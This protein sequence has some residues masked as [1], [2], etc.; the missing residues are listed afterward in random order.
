MT[1]EVHAEI[2]KFLSAQRTMSLATADADGVPMA[3]GMHYYP[4]G[5]R[6]YVSSLPYTK[7]LANI[8]VNPIVGYTV[9]RLPSYEKRDT[10]RTLQVKAAASV[11]TDETQLVAVQGGLTERYPWAEELQLDVNVILAF[12]PIELLW[13]DISKGLDGRLVHTFE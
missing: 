10:A 5:L 8:E 4:D 6:L 13:M 7:K 2:E 9:W 3:H 12:E 11:V 1:P